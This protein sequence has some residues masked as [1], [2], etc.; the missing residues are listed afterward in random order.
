[1]VGNT[2]KVRTHMCPG[3]SVA[4]GELVPITAVQYLCKDEDQPE[5][6]LRFKHLLAQD[7]SVEHVDWQ[8][9]D[10]D[11]LGSVRA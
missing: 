3:D 6:V 5:P 11:R 9:R 4:Q 2:D 8:I 10:F 1:M 7:A